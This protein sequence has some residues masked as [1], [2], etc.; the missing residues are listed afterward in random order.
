MIPQQRQLTPPS[1]TC[2]SKLAWS[3]NFLFSISAY[4]LIARKKTLEEQEKN[5]IITHLGPSTFVALAFQLDTILDCL[6]SELSL[7]PEEEEKKANVGA[8]VRPWELY[9]DVLQINQGN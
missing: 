1:F 7:N 5:H 3:R 4:W 2:S 6:E 8:N 9:A